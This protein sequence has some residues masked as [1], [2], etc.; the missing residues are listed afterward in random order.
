M[1][2]H[3]PSS[4]GEPTKEESWIL[5]YAVGFSVVRRFQRCDQRSRSKTRWPSFCS[6]CKGSIPDDYRIYLD[7]S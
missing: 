3:D 1:Q 2:H 4:V 7:K 6:L 5:G